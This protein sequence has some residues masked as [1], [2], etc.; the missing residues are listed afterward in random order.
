MIV[1]WPS[2]P[3]SGSVAHPSYASAAHPYEVGMEPL[4]R[5]SRPPRW[6]RPHLLPGPCLPGMYARAFLEGRISSDRPDGFR[7]EHSHPVDGSRFK[8]LPLAPTPDVG[9]LGVPDGVHG[10]GPM[11]AIYQAHSTST[12]TTGASGHQPAAHGRSSATRW[13]SQSRGALG[14]G[15]RTR[16]PHLRRQLQPAAPRR[17]GAATARS[18][19]RLEAFRAA[20]WNV[21]KVV[22]GRGWDP[23]LAADGDGALVHPHE[24]HGSDGDYQTFRA[25]DGKVRPRLLLRARPRTRRMVENWSDEDVWES[26]AAAVTTTTR[27]MPPTRGSDRAHRA[28][29]G[30]PRQDDRGYGLGTRL[31]RPQRDPPEKKLTLATSR[32]SATA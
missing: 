15:R 27:S 12:S 17:S 11:N 7:Q 21:I 16:Q 18:S 26:Q 31:R 19:R 14:C 32:A 13:M 5:G 28:A 9:L 10:L 30:H 2:G 4:F 29:H 8:A 24:C 25:N 20:G 1:H 23:L 22:W 6:W 3:A